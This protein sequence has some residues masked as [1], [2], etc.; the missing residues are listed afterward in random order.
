MR[1]KDTSVE[2]LDRHILE[3]ETHLH[4]I[5]E[6]R[7]KYLS[8][9]LYPIPVTDVVLG[10]LTRYDCR[11]FRQSPSAILSPH[12]TCCVVGR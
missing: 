12:L 5:E 3:L 9:L 7:R 4:D 8:D 6:L 11:G 10:N 1:D 2:T